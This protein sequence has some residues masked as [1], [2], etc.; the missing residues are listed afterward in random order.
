MLLSLHKFLPRVN[1]QLLVLLKL[2]SSDEIYKELFNIYH[3]SSKNCMYNYISF[4]LH[5]RLYQ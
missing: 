3:F 5:V 4:T 2:S 1:L